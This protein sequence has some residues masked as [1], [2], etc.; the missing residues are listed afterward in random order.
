MDSTTDTDNGVANRPRKVSVLPRPPLTK[1][2]FA[3]SRPHEQPPLQVVALQVE[4]PSWWQLANDAVEASGDDSS[5]PFGARLWPSALGIA[6]FLVEYNDRSEVNAMVDRPILELG[7][8]GGLC[9]IVAA[10]LG[11]QV[12]A[13]DISRTVLEL[14]NLGWAATC[15]QL[16]K[17]RAKDEQTN[18]VTSTGS[19]QTAT[20]DLASTA[21]LPLDS[22]STNH[23]PIV[24]AAAMLYSNELAL[25]LA[26]RTFEATHHYN[27]WVI[28]GDDDSGERG[29]GRQQ[30]LEEWDRL[31]AQ[32][33]KCVP[34]AI[35]R[36]VVKNQALKWSEKRIQL[37]HLNH[38]NDIDGA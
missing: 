33:E 4:D 7:C 31:E 32:A 15:K 3:F 24:M 10:S 14:T 2:T 11:G 35:T 38:P 5:N 13:S 37:I 22:S 9:S 19:L 1:R 26:R 30:F 29:G 12:V 21:P 23:Q 27:A 8:G 6:Q 25:L 16:Q 20:V 17:K 28:I 36:S 18:L 34:C